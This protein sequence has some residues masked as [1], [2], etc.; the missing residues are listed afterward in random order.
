MEW[1]EMAE[2]SCIPCSFTDAHPPLVTLGD[3]DA[4]AA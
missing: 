3:A 2:I 1:M 4:V